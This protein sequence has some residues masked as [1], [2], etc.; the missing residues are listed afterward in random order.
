MKK[1]PFKLKSGNKPSMSKM[2]GIS[3]M[4]KDVTASGIGDLSTKTV[5]NEKKYFDG[6]KE[7]DLATFVRTR[8][9]R[10]KKAKKINPDY[11]PLPFEKIT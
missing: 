10:I 5:G 1:G 9:E 7:I 11:K 8:R 6:K 2:A 4:K 3:P